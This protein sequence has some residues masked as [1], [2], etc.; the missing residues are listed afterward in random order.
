MP[1]SCQRERPGSLTDVR[2]FILFSPRVQRLSELLVAL[3]KDVKED[4]TT[5]IYKRVFPA[6]PEYLGGKEQQ[7]LLG[8]LREAN[9]RLFQHERG[10]K[11]QERLTLQG[12]M[13][14]NVFGSWRMTRGR[15][16]DFSIQNELTHGE[17]RKRSSIQ[18]DIILIEETLEK[19]TYR[20]PRMA[21]SS[22]S[23]S[24]HN[25]FSVISLPFDS[26]PLFHSV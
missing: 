19:R 20:S 2:E 10:S 9:I 26:H 3:I 23:L 24:P 7:G 13:E 4:Q 6:K 14:G 5:L 16:V 22:S 15:G 25:N 12:F 17:E 21:F 1:Q 8:T 11:C 18:M